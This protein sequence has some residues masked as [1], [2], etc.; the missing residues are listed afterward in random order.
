MISAEYFLHASN[1]T[2]VVSVSAKD[3]LWLRVFAIL[4]SLIGL[5]YFYLQTT[6]R[7]AIRAAILSRA[8][9]AFDD[10][11]GAGGAD[12]L[13]RR[14]VKRDFAR[15]T[16]SLRNGQNSVTYSTLLGCSNRGGGDGTKPNEPRVLTRVG[17]GDS[18]RVVGPR[19]H[20]ATLH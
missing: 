4:A 6:V 20:R 9:S 16:A 13:S 11:V 18:R 19:Q 8:R 5:P 12:R 3:V 1:I 17:I 2:R 14:A 7:S 15:R 10:L